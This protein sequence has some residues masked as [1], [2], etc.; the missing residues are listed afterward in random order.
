MAML[1]FVVAPAAF[2]ALF[3][4]NGNNNTITGTG[5]P[6]TIRGFGGNDTL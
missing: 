3:E 1:V 2:A 5:N 6:D 4:G